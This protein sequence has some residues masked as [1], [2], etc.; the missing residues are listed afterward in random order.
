MLLI[1][2][3][4]VKEK[5]WLEHQVDILEAEEAFNNFSG[6]SLVDNRLK[7]QRALLPNVDFG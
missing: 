6:Y 3:E 7:N 2:S 5:I 1:A 4:A